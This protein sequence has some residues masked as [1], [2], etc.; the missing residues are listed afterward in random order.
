MNEL[1]KDIFIEPVKPK[2]FMVEIARSVDILDSCGLTKKKFTIEFILS[3][4]EFDKTFYHI[5]KKI[6]TYGDKPKNDFKV[7]FSGIE[8]K[9]V[10]SEK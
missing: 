4:E 6:I 2:D 7:N 1:P 9:F 3:P 5:S 10:K 8:V